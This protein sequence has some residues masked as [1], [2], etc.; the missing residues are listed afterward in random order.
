MLP[1][2]E[3]NTGEGPNWSGMQALVVLAVV[4]S[5]TMLG[6]LFVDQAPIEARLSYSEIKQKIRDGDIQSAELHEH[7]IVVT[8][9]ALD[10][11]EAEQFGAVIPM[12]GDPELLSLLEEQG[13]EITATEPEDVSIFAYLLPWVLILGVYLWLQRRMMSNIAGG[14][15]GGGL[16][17]GPGGVAG[18]ILGGRFMK[19]SKP[20]RKTTF[21]DVAGQDQAKQEVAELVEFLRDPEKFH[22]VGAEV[23]HGVLLVG[24]PG[25]GKTLL[26]KALAGEAD[27][28][29]F[30]TSGSEFIEIFV[31]VGAG[32][33]RKMFEEARK[34]APSIIFID[35]L[36]SIGRTRGTGLGGGHDERE[37]TLNQILAELDG[38]GEREAVV[39]LAATNRPDVLDPALLRPGRFDRHVTL[40]LPDKQARRAILDIHARKL[41]LEDTSD[42]DMVA[43]GTPG[44]SGA[45]LKNLLNEAAIGTARRNA[46]LIT[47][48]DLDE[49]RDKVM[50]GTVRTLAIRPQERH[51]LAVHEAG[52]AAVAYFTPGA[53]PLYKVT[54]IPRGQAL[55][56]THTLPESERH[57]LDED[58]LHT[59]LVI[60]LAGRAAER[61]FLGT[62]SSGADDD[63][64]RATEQARSMVARWGMTEDLGPVDLRQSEDHPFLGRTIAQPTSHSDATAAAVDRAVIEL[65]KT[66]EAAATEALTQHR[67]QV[68]QLISRLEA[69]ETL[70]FD[71]IRA[72]LDPERVVEQPERALPPIGKVPSVQ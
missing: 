9:K 23:P 71:A 56:G 24:P 2:P 18:N 26:A 45:D 41:P 1:D 36:D 28:P 33:V 31:G 3:K 15:L 59:Q 48:A 4:L 57:T 27:V 58:F 62:V 17:G 53:D 34:A 20:S 22:R 70:G 14:G 5:L 19:P 13:I 68:D 10:A 37:Q 63:I 66:A 64:R 55:G 35:E 50:M 46:S 67:G 16:G 65:L 21:N 30:S 44:F 49:A 32:R 47:R 52:H 6:S 8:T 43:A 12:Q 72:C 54:I 51:R 42:L 11:A 69:D 38:F 25:T 61:L 7:D 29:F 40:N 60:L 39:V